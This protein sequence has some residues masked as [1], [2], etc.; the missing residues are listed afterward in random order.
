M[1]LR[2][3]WKR[4]QGLQK[5][6]IIKKLDLEFDIFRVRYFPTFTNLVIEWPLSGRFNKTV[7][8]II[9]PALFVCLYQNLFYFK[10]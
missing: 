10:F 2:L 9:F 3:G 7:F 1:E 6:L 4:S 8:F 5:L